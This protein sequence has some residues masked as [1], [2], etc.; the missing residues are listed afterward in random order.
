MSRYEDGGKE[1]EIPTQLPMQ[2]KIPVNLRQ[3]DELSESESFHSLNQSEFSTMNSRFK[4]RVNS[5]VPNSEKK[6]SK[7]KQ[8]SDKAFTLRSRPTYTGNGGDNQVLQEIAKL[9]RSHAVLE[10]NQRDI[11]GLL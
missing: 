5:L 10:K 6:E 2:E 4:I 9:Q 11:L 7:F 1:E 3:I 8:F